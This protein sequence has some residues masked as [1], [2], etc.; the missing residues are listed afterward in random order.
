VKCALDREVEAWLAAL[1]EGALGTGHTQKKLRSWKRAHPGHLSFTVVRHPLARAYEAFCRFILPTE[2]PAFLGIRHTLAT[3]YGVDLPEDPAAP[4][5]DLA[6]HARAFEGFLGFVKGNLKGQTSVRVD[7]AWAS[8]TAILHGVTRAALPDRVIRAERL[9]RALEEIAADLGVAA[10]EL[11]AED[12]AG[13]PPL[14]AI[15]DDTIE[16]AARAAYQKDYMMFGYRAWDQ[17]A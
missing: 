16:A 17:A 7:G 15:Y 10:P 5:Y 3:R 13:L 2:G 6:A 4:S 11:P 12:S 9:P 14:A 8:Q 1:S